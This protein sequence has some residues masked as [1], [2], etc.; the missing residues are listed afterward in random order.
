M[1]KIFFLSSCSTCQRILKQLSLPADVEII[2]IKQ[3]NISAEVLDKIALTTGSYEALFS[4]KA[5][6]YKVLLQ[7]DPTLG[8]TV[9]RKHILDE[10][11]FLRRPVIIYNDFLSVGN[12][13]NEV[14]KAR[15]YFDQLFML[16]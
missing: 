14:E 16:K 8:E 9:Y 13:P 12:N 15:V 5:M 1:K 4:K 10:Y 2:D 11:T 3:T 6:K 7:T